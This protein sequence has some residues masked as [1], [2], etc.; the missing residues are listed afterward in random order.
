L[1]AL[2]SRLTGTQTLHDLQ[3]TKLKKELEH[4]KSTLS[5]LEETSQNAESAHRLQLIAARSEI[6]D[7]TAK[8]ATSEDL[9]AKQK[10][11]LDDLSLQADESTGSIADLT[12]KLATSEDIV[13]KQKAEFRDL[14]L[15]ADKSKASVS[16]LTAKLAA[17]EDIVTKQK[18]ELQDLDAKLV[19]SNTNLAAAQMSNAAKAARLDK[20]KQKKREDMY[21]LQMDHATERHRMKTEIE[22]LQATIKEQTEDIEE[23]D[24]Y[25]SILVD[26]VKQAQ[27]IFEAFGVND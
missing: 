9:V 12:A 14:G 19:V 7:L 1:S 15:Q 10:V 17:S 24:S 26:K 5:Q 16:D 2:K 20:Q 21:R 8:L 25:I 27:V 3:A 11:E 18:A 6:S 23:C 22:G 4:V 13:T